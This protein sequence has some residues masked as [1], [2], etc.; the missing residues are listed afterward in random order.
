MCSREH[1]ADFIAW[2]FSYQ[3]MY[4]KACFDLLVD[5]DLYDCKQCAESKE[6]AVTRSALTVLHDG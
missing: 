5:G 3:A 2:S 6:T 4:N 1:F